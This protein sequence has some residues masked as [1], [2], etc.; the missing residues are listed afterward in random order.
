MPDESKAKPHCKQ[1]G[2]CCKV[3]AAYFKWSE[4]QVEFLVSRHIRHWISDQAVIAL[5]P[6]VC[7]NLDAENKCK[8][9]DNGKP[10][11]CSTF[12]SDDRHPLPGCAYYE[13]NGK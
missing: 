9:H 1:C 2:R 10:K 5:I 8:L 4:E 13:S 7:P 11:A 12:P 6:H 3:I